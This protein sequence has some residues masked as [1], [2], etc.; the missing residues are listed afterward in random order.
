MCGYP[1]F[2]ESR[3]VVIGVHYV[4]AHAEIMRVV[5]R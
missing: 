2:K 5:S 4:G 1:E 3:S